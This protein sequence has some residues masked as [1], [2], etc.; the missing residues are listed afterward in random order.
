MNYNDTACSLNT[1]IYINV[2]YCITKI[3]ILAIIQK[4][5]KIF[6]AL[7]NAKIIEV[8]AILSTMFPCIKRICRINLIVS[9]S[10]QNFSTMLF[11]L[12]PLSASS[13]LQGMMFEIIS[14]FGVDLGLFTNSIVFPAIASRDSQILNYLLH[15][16]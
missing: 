6:Y 5:D 12:D 7:V 14:S 13:S 4:L 9:S 3:K 11:T 10:L 8:Y 16:V 15:S 2:A 1:L